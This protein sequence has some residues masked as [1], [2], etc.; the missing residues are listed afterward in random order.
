[1]QYKI[2]IHYMINYIFFKKEMKVFVIHTIFSNAQKSMFFQRHRGVLV[3][4]Q[5]LVSP[6]ALEEMT[7][8]V[9]RATEMVDVVVVLKVL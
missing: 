4:D 3:N 2:N 9:R 8:T 1:M 5:P 7:E 6:S